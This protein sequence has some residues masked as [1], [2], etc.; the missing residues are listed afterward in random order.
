MSRSEI[1]A[2][3]KLIAALADTMT[4]RMWSSDILARCRQIR[5]AVDVIERSASRNLG[6]DR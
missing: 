5:E 4:S 1:E 2:Q 6:G 3:A